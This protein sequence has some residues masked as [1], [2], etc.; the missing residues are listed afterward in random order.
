AATALGRLDD[1]AAYLAIGVP[2]AM[3]ETPCALPYLLARA[4]FRLATGDTAAALRDL[5]AGEALTAAW[6]LDSPGLSPW[7]TRAA[8]AL[9]EAGRPEQA[10]ALLDDQLVR[11][12]AAARDPDAASAGWAAAGY[13]GDVLLDER[14][15][16]CEHRARHPA[17]TARPGSAK[18]PPGGARRRG[19]G[20]GG[21][22]GRGRTPNSTSPS[23][24]RSAA[25]PSWPRSAGPTARSPPT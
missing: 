1:A 2:E 11:G 24:T 6:G 13:T 14:A 20:R 16:R 3:F 12:P 5:R 8:G 7:H 17:R 18:T 19:R 23:P 4:R 22:P 15:E 25:W 21:G 10:A 9:V